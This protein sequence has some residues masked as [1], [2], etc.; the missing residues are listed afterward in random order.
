MTWAKLEEKVF[1]GKDF[2]TLDSRGR[3]RFPL[4]LIDP[5][6]PGMVVTT[7]IHGPWLEVWPK[8]R[9][10]AFYA[11]LWQKVSMSTLTGFLNYGNPDYLDTVRNLVE[12]HYRVTLDESYR[13]VLPKNL[14]SEVG[15]EL[16]D[17]VVLVGAVEFT[18]IWP[19]KVYHDHKSARGIQD[20]FLVI[21]P[22]G[23]GG[24]EFG[25]D[26]SARPDSAEELDEDD[27]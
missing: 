17:S 26:I 22:D 25:G 14:R 24:N 7:S 21:S 3:V 9:Y 5:D 6:N 2:A 16:G 12:N 1:T 23:L 11:A 4:H 13:L 19:E 27:S 8:W 10:E 18:E 15:L 20:P